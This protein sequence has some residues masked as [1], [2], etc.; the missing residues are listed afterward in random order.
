MRILIGIAFTFLSV[1][2]SASDYPVLRAS[3]PFSGSRFYIPN[4]Q[5]QHTAIVML[6]GS[7]GGSEPYLDPEANILATQ[8]YAVL[9][10][11][12]FDCNRGLVGPRETLKQVDTDL[13]PNAVEWL[14]KQAHSNG[15]VII[16]GFS[17]GAELTL[18]AGS[19]N[20]TGNRKASALIAH[21][22]SDVF[23]GP[24]NWSWREPACWLCKKGIG[25]CPQGSPKSD[26]QWNPSCGPDDPNQMD[27]TKSA[28]LVNGQVIASRSRIE[29]ER[30]DRPVLIT[31]G[32]R[33][34]VWP[35]DQTRR[36]ESILRAAGK[37]PEVHYF[38][39]G[40]HGFRGADEIKR[41][42]LVL[43]FLRRVR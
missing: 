18:V 36:I 33:D 20:S 15:K 3:N 28:W 41:R 6:H 8:G 23:N 35:V 40:G 25:Q 12:Y 31:V 9:V 5:A 11:C 34:E 10:L 27:F 2:A 17:R 42:E 43:S 32:E 4:D 26:F 21:S 16:Y 24:F 19:L 14:R 30:Y 38:P 29:I 1:V 39:N 13:V 37:S 7:E 22:P